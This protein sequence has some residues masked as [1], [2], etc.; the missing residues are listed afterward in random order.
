M[1]LATNFPSQVAA[2]SVTSSSIVDGSVGLS[3]LN[4]SEVKLNSQ[5]FTGNGTFNVPT[6]VTW[7]I[8]QSTTGI[9][10]TLTVTSGGSVSITIGGTSYFGSA[11]FP[12]GGNL[13][14]FWARISQ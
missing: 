9:G 8:V 6:G 1:P 3:K 10:Y 5:T 11:S 4:S 12:G 13:T 7:V 2:G 14:I